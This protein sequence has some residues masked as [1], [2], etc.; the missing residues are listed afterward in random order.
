[1]FFGEEEEKFEKCKEEILGNLELKPYL[2]FA[3]LKEEKDDLSKLLGLNSTKEKGIIKIGNSIDIN[4]SKEKSYTI[5]NYHSCNKAKEFIFNNEYP[6]FKN[7][8][9]NYIKRL[10]KSKVKMIILLLNTNINENN[11][12]KTSSTTTPSNYGS[13]LNNLDSVK[14]LQE[15]YSKE[16]SSSEIIYGYL[17]M[18]NEDDLKLFEYFNINEEDVPSIV[19][20]NFDNKKHFVDNNKLKTINDFVSRVQE[21]KELITQNKLNWFSGNFIEDLLFSLGYEITPASLMILVVLVMVLLFV[22]ISLCSFFFESRRKNKIASSLKN[23][24]TANA[25][26]G[27]NTIIKEEKS[28]ANLENKKKLD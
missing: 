11:E 5:H 7:L 2:Y 21:L 6:L 23:T 16:N 18:K 9:I 10:Q 4:S 20:Y 19:L 14:F 12:L 24:S 17:N 27:T 25:N 15:H 1:M 26:T 8:S 3:E 22:L 13:N 28:K